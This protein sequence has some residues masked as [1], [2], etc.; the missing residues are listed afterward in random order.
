MTGEPF[1]KIMDTSDRRTLNAIYEKDIE[2]YL[3]I[4]IKHVT[5]FHS[6]YM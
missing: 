3:P 6:D 2:L 4:L 1:N 5:Q